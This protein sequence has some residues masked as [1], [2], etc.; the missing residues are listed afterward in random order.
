M[1]ETWSFKKNVM[2]G[3][4]DQ[5]QYLIFTR[6]CIILPKIIWVLTTYQDIL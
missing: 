4:G 3:A 6:Q 1:D 2:S 5:I